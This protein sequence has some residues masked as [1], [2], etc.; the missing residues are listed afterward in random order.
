MKK[1][2]F[3]HTKHKR[4]WNTLINAAKAQQP[5]SKSDVYDGTNFSGSLCY[6]C[7]AAT[8]FIISNPIF[9]YCI[10][11]PLQLSCNERFSVFYRYRR[12]R[13]SLLTT[14]DTDRY[15]A[16]MLEYINVCRLI[17]DA[18]IDKQNI[19]KYLVK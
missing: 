13:F 11:C 17:R 6:A 12:A 14:D 7:D 10:H 19:K 8:R 2:L 3:N 16:E 5:L 9:D 18:L 15:S 1:M 4:M